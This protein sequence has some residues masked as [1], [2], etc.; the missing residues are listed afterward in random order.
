M[1]RKLAPATVSPSVKLG[2]G[3]RRSLTGGEV[4]PSAPMRATE[5]G[6]AVQVSIS[7]TGQAPSFISA[8]ASTLQK[9]GQLRSGLQE[10]ID[11]R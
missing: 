11:E 3:T 4:Q 7:H 2:G 1:Y 8:W 6:G 9:R 5:V 10:E